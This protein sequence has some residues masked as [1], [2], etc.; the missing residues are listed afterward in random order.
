[1]DNNDQMLSM[2]KMFNE[3][4]AEVV[5]HQKNFKEVE[6]AINQLNGNLNAEKMINGI[7][8]CCLKSSTPSFVDD[9]KYYAETVLSSGHELPGDFEERVKLMLS[10][11]CGEPVLEPKKP[12]FRLIY[13]GKD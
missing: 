8:M 13:G 12:Q 10:S 7:L 1:M 5:L 4:L 2:L 9:F 3:L 6:K 11:V